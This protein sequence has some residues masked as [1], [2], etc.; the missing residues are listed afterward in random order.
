M[1]L[2]D[3]SGLLALFNRREPRHSAVRTAVENEPEPLVVSP[4]VIAEL[5]CLIATRLG[6]EAELTVLFELAGGAYHL[7]DFPAEDLARAQSVIERYSDQDIG[8]A[9]AS[10]VVL[11]DRYRTTAVLTFDHRH[12]NTVRPLAGGSFQLLP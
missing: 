1:I 5:D 10:I 2:A 6:V 8:A 3:T 12:F 7:A 11:A 4:Y 9:D